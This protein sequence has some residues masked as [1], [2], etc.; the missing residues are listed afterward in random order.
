[1]MKAFIFAIVGSCLAGTAFAQEY[2]CEFNVKK[3]DDYLPKEMTIVIDTFGDRVLISDDLDGKWG[4]GKSVGRITVN[5][6]KRQT[7]LWSIRPGIT[8][9]SPYQGEPMMQIDYSATM[10]KASPRVQITATPVI[11]WHAH[12]YAQTAKGTCVQK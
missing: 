10:R 3:R 6:A 8:I 12:T 7:F 1:M 11:R 2:V 5:N 9:Q 4:H